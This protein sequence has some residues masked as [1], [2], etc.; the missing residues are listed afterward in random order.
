MRKEIDVTNIK[1]IVVDSELFDV[2]T[3]GD[4]MVVSS[5]LLP[6]VVES[7]FR[8]LSEQL[9]KIES[10]TRTLSLNLQK[11]ENKINVLNAV[12]QGK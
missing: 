12:M 10:T 3:D 2:K 5:N 1:K 7:N 8:E 4:M 6:E 9:D 11:A